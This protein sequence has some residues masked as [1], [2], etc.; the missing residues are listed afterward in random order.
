MKR[1]KCE[2]AVRACIEAGPGGELPEGIAGHLG[3]CP[4]CRKEKAM[5]DKTLG[6]AVAPDLEEARAGIDWDALAGRITDEVFRTAAAR[7]EKAKRAR[8]PAFRFFFGSRPVLAGLLLGVVLGSLATFYVLR[9]RGRG[10]SGPGYYASDKF[11][12][13]LETEAA[14]RQLIDYLD[15][16]R[17]ILTDFYGA[18]G[19]AAGADVRAGRRAVMGLLNEKR[20]LN[21][22]LEKQRMIKAKAVCDQIEV[23]FRELIKQEPGLSA[24]EFE[25]LKGMIEESN[26]LLK[27]KIVK[28]EIEGEA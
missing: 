10:P 5:I 7:A 3:D 1:T 24:L 13:R 9:G 21:P 16:S 4:E 20:Y 2:E 26:L 18:G 12:D 27:I 25:R 11:I 23:L 14:R 19:P 6:A 28:K 15:K 8:R 22:Q 17:F